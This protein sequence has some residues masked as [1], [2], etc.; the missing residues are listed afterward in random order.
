MNALHVEQIGK[1]SSSKI[2]V[3]D[4]KIYNGNRS[5]VFSNRDSQI[6]GEIGFTTAVMSSYRYNMREYSLQNL[7]ALQLYIF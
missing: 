3:D 6:D 7:T 2:W 4:I 1:I 5:A